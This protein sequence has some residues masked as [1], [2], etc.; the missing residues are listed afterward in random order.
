MLAA[1]VSSNKKQRLVLP[2]Q[3]GLG[4]SLMSAD[5][6][7][8]RQ[9]RIS[10]W[11]GTKKRGIRLITVVLPAPEAPTKATIWPALTLRLKLVND[12]CSALGYL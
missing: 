6:E 4:C 1:M 10:P 8:C 9:K 7:I 12:G 11:F 3:S 2:K 5:F